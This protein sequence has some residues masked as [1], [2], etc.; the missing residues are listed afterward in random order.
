MAKGGR[1]TGTYPFVPPGMSPLLFF[2]TFFEELHQLV[3]AMLF[4]GSLFFG[5]QVFLE[6]LDQPVQWNFRIGRTQ[7]FKLLVELVK[8]LIESIKQAFV[9]D[10]GHA[11]Q[12][13]EIRQCRRHDLCTQ[14]TQQRQVFLCRYRQAMGTQMVE[15]IDQHDAVAL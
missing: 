6:F 11:C 13:I 15:K 1:S 5:A 14:H 7:G 10:Q 4:D 9:L 8:R 3:P 12:M 2:Q